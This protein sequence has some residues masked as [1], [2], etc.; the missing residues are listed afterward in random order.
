MQTNE[1]MLPRSNVHETS[2]Q[3]IL[4]ME[5]R[6]E[7]E[8]VKETWYLIRRI[9]GSWTSLSLDNLWMDSCSVFA[10]E[11]LHRYSEYQSRF[12]YSTS[13]GTDLVRINK[14]NEFPCILRYITELWGL[15]HKI[16]TTTL[17]Y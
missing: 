7:F 10:F 3:H 8:I 12:S 9:I 2:G 1:V 11:C 16:L 15:E 17:W 14:R 4:W 5:K 6:I 13:I